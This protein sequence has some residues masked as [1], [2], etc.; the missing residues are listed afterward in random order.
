MSSRVYRSCI[1]LLVGALCASSLV[2]ATGGSAAAVGISDALT[3]PHASTVPATDP[4]INTG[5]AVSHGFAVDAQEPAVS[6]DGGP[7]GL[8]RLRSASFT[9]SSTDAAATFECALAPSKPV[10]TACSRAKSYAALADGA[11]TFQV[12]ATDAAGNVG[13]AVSRT[14]TV[15]ATPPV[16]T[17]LT[18]PDMITRDT[19]PTYT[20]SISEPA[21]TYCSLVPSE[22]ADSFNAC[23]SPVTFSG[24]TDGR[25]RF[26]MRAV[27]PAGNITTVV[28]NRFGS[29]VTQKFIVDTVAPS[30]AIPTRPAAFTSDTSPT[31]GF[32]W[33]VGAIARCSLRPFGTPAKFDFCVTPFAFDPLT[34]GTYTFSLIA[35]DAAGN[36]SAPLS[37]SFTVDTS[38]PTVSTR[39][40]ALGARAISQT[41]NVAVGFSERV[42]GV[43]GTSLT[44]ATADG[45]DVPASVTYSP[46]TRLAILNPT[47]TLSADTSYTATLTSA[48]KD[49]AGNAVAPVSW[50]FVTGRGPTATVRPLPNSTGISVS[51]QVTATFNEPVTGVTTSSFTLNDEVG[52]TV[53]ASVAY[54]PVTRV[55][56]LSPSAPLTAGTPYTATLTSAVTD[57]AGNPF[58]A[59]SWNFTTRP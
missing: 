25:Y 46:G 13:M 4:A 55:A 34:E 33:D 44:L 1:S 8:I 5:L 20:F 42:T 15:D 30:R 7:S 45:N 12:R 21:T 38:A 3:R 39:S 16:V 18:Q 50:T 41:A 19:S 54:D 52:E 2:L 6:I 35:T 28:R 40:P 22:A 26:A 53:T 31:I 9:F 47:A 37:T 48:V 36:T 56:T 23:T 59:R 32:T 11:Y 57:L 43:G 10:F 17:V 29:L 27:D 24:L 49:R 58:A 51:S 14:F